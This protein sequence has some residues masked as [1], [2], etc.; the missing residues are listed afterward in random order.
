M[1]KPCSSVKPITGLVWFGLISFPLYLWHWPLLSF[2]RIVE[3][4]T[5]SRNIR[6]AAVLISV[7]L[8]WLTYKFIEKPVRFGK[9]GS[10][11]TIV[12]AVLMTIVGFSG[13]IV[14]KA[15]FSQAHTITRKSLEHKIGSSLAW[16]RGKGDWLFLGK[17]YDDTVAKLKLSIVPTE[18]E[19]EATTEIFTK[20][21]TAAA[22]SNIKVA[23]IIGPNKSSI[24]PEYLPNELVPST[25]RYS[26]FFLD[27]LNNVPNLTVYNPTNDFLRLKN[28]EGILYWMTNTHWN[29]KGAFLG[30]SGLSKL[31]DLPIPQVEFQQGLIAPG[32]LISISKLEFFHFTQKITGMLFGN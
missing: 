3:S 12:L 4:E 14:N 5:P 15:D 7:L 21:A 30:Y 16:Y 32:D 28:T 20:I 8:A 18:S 25:K 31:L 27:K 19:V 2:A 22:Q 9:F 13:F 26:S 23:L 1:V 6:I 10:V 17:A 24:Y 11:K 29:N